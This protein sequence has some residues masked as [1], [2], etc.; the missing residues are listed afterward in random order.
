[1]APREPDD[2]DLPDAERAHVRRR[3]RKRETRMVV[4]NASVRRLLGV[5]RKRAG[6]Q[7]HPDRLRRPED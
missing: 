5:I 1:M 3:D 4:D 6:R 7:R 2:N